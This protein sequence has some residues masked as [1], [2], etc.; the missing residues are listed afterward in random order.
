MS[1]SFLK[2]PELMQFPPAGYN[3]TILT[4]HF[5][6]EGGDSKEIYASPEADLLNMLLDWNPGLKNLIKIS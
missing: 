4:F 2:Y 5:P 1:I 3:H 6:K